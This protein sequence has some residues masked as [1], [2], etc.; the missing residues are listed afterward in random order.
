[1]LSKTIGTGENLSLFHPNL[2]TNSGLKAK[3]SENEYQL[4][5]VAENIGRLRATLYRS[6]E[7]C[8]C[9]LAPSKHESLEIS[10]MQYPKLVRRGIKNLSQNLK[11]KAR[12]GAIQVVL[13]RRSN[14]EVED[15]GEVLND[16]TN[17]CLEFLKLVPSKNHAFSLHCVHLTLTTSVTLVLHYL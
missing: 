11:I 13:R 17:L 3:T 15:L 1:M 12:G 5:R 2:L 10:V 7:S 8:L 6:P 14:A 9:L 4:R 16:Y